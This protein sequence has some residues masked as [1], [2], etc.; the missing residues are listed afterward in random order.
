VDALPDGGTIVIGTRDDV[1]AV[2]LTVRDTGV[3]MTEEV[4]L[5]CLEPFFTTKRD[6]GT[7]LG[8][9][10]VYGIVKRHQ[11]ALEITSAPGQGTT[12]SIR[13][14]IWSH[15]APEAT[16]PSLLRAPLPL[17]VLVIEDEPLIRQAFVEYL[18]V[19]GHTV[20]T[21][22]NGRSG[23]EMF[24]VGKFDLVLTDRALPE[25][26]GDQVASSI[27][28]LE[29][30]LPIIMVTGFGDLMKQQSQRPEGVSLVVSKPLTLSGLRRAIAQV[31]G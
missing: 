1:D 31:T 17:R 22:S 6:H 10:L 2:V 3:G 15:D 12:M 11:G 5:R 18:H 16:V 19:D 27:K 30:D 20:K 7:G 13:L 4:R 25:M 9:G 8:L 14:P 28:Q 29:P 21:A 23:L 24:Q 26:G